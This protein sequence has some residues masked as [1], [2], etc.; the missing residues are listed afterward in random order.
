MDNQEAKFILRAYRPSGAD[1]ANPQFADALEQSRRDPALG[2]WF[3]REQ[4][5]DRVV[6][7]KLRAVTPPAG[8]R[9]TILTGA[10]V[11]SPSRSWWQQGSWM[12]MAAAAVIAIGLAIGWPRLHARV[13][14]DKAAAWAM[15]DMLHGRHGGSG[16][17][18]VTLATFLGKPT[19][20]LAGATLPVTP[21]QLRATGCRTISFGGHDVA[22]IC[23]LHAG[24]QYH[25][26]VM[27]GTARLP[28]SP[29]ILEQPGA[30]A[31]A[32]SDGHYGYVLATAAGPSALKALL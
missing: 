24:T 21:E 18:V 26:Y 3:E 23:F 13:D 31:A 1:A 7:Q 11:S 19:T 30:A 28:N 5:L 12:G 2:K 14:A 6:A 27:T 32:W 22:E 10:R 16:E 8:L 17:A 15:D 20:H 25:L 4:A 9:E 29:K